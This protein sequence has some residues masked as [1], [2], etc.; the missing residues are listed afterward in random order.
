MPK[1]RHLVEYAFVGTP[2]QIEAYRRRLRE[3]MEPTEDPY[4][5]L[6]Q[7]VGLILARR[8]VAPPEI[9]EE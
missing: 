6:A 3:A 7:G 9:E 4:L 1:V 2:E 5:R 8:H